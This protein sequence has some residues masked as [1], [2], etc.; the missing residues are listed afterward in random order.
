[1]LLV[2]AVH[3]AEDSTLQPR[4]SAEVRTEHTHFPLC[5]PR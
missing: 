4:L 5:G 3:R 1:M 2:Q